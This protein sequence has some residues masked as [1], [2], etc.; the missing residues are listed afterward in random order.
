[1]KPQHQFNQIRSITRSISPHYRASN[2]SSLRIVALTI[3]LSICLLVTTLGCS[4][5]EQAQ[6]T[7]SPLAYLPANTLAFGTFDA[8]HPK[9]RGYMTS[10]G[11]LRYWES[12]EKTLHSNKSITGDWS[13]YL[14][15][16]RVLKLA[17]DPASAQASP[18]KEMV[19][20]VV[21]ESQGLATAVYYNI[22]PGT[23]GRDL[24]KQLKQVLDGA[25]VVTQPI[26]GTGFEG[27]SFKLLPDDAAANGAAANPVLKFYYDFLG[28]NDCF[29]AA[30]NNRLVFASSK[31]LLERGFSPAQ[32]EFKAFLESNDYKKVE[33]SLGDLQNV[34][35]FG[36]ANFAE[37]VKAVP[38]T[39]KAQFPSFSPVGL[40]KASFEKDLMHFAFA[41]PVDHEA[42]ILG[43]YVAS[44]P[45]PAGELFL[46]LPNG[47]IGAVALDAGTAL[48]LIKTVAAEQGAPMA[49]FNPALDLLAK[50]KTIGVAALPPPQGRS[51]GI[52]QGMML[53]S[54]LVVIETAD[55]K[56]LT[57]E[58]EQLP[59]K[60]GIPLPLTWVDSTV[61]GLPARA[62]DMQLGFKLQML[63]K[64]NLVLLSNDEVAL[65]GFI[66]GDSGK[67][68]AQQLR[69]T[70]I[71]KPLLTP[72][73]APAA[74]IYLDYTKFGPTLQSL[75]PGGATMPN[76]SL[77]QFQSMGKVAFVAGYQQ[78]ILRLSMSQELN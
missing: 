59:S 1:M 14:A 36:A 74:G 40:A 54:G 51:E 21:K 10:K 20:F 52:P 73:G 45:R 53:P 56:V 78:G 63:A 77:E 49:Q 25:K 69:D 57:A 11:Y 17:P 72:A 67:N 13:A 23:D 4:K 12:M 64:D 9:I 58:I 33:S 24:V 29:V 34:I 7:A 39:F 27:V 44:L 26:A 41:L 60:L 2:I 38:A 18:Y 47:A 75:T 71:L 55:A 35:G 50:I 32:N 61:S 8:S 46:K 42:S 30:S 5:K 68:T 48:S 6:P 43:K 70:P 31:S 22:A 76:A 62:V 15:A 19:F 16:M 37:I 3:C 28:L 65:A 66:S